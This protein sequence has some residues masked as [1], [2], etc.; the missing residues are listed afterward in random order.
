M[1]LTVQIVKCHDCWM[2]S[3]AELPQIIYK[4]ATEK[5]VRN[6]A[7]RL[8]HALQSP[9]IRID[10]VTDE[11]DVILVMN[12]DGREDEEENTSCSCRKHEKSYALAELS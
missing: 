12:R 11:G 2:A 4:A 3:F 8:Q 7:T 9:N 1:E 6:R 5:E 10:R